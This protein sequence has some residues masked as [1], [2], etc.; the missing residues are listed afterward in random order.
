MVKLIGRQSVAFLVA[1]VLCINMAAMSLWTWR[2]FASSQGFADVVTDMLEEPALRQVIAS[3]IVTALENQ[4][5]TAS[6]AVTARPVIEQV[7]GEIVASDAFRG[8]FHAGVQ[9]LHSAMIQ[10]HRS[11]LLVH[12]D[13]AAPLVK[14]ALRLI[15]PTLA[16][17][18]PDSALQVVVGISQNTPIDIAIRVSELAGWAAAPFA[19]LGVSCFVMAAKRSNERRRTVEL[20]GLSLVCL[21]VAWFAFLA[22]GVNVVADWG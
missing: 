22:I 7:V 20:V 13:D 6:A 19:S 10:G 5:A 14:D 1:G 15:N 9:E 17:A 12:V 2:T 18:L 4:S 21:G 3:Q 16:D 8:V 11:R